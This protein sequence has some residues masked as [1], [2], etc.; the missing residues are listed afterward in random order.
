[1]GLISELLLECIF[2]GA[3][4]IAAPTGNAKALRSSL[5]KEARHLWR[6]FL[7]DYPICFQHPG[8][9]DDYIVAFC[10]QQAKLVVELNGFQECDKKR[11]ELLNKRTKDIELKGFK[12]VFIPSN[13]INRHFSDVCEYIDNCVAKQMRS[14]A[15]IL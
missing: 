8:V 10:C 2:D 9:V 4:G 5:T 13:E 12:V 14:D 1:M 7:R 3:F 11:K 6:D 15:P